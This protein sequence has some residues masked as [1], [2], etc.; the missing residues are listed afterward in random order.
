MLRSEE[1]RK[2]AHSSSPATDEMVGE[3]CREQELHDVRYA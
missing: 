1:P 2:G 3:R